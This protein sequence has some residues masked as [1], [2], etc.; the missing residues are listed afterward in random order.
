MK[1]LLISVIA[2]FLVF[3]FC[4]YAYFTPHLTLTKIQEAA[5]TG[6][7]RA[8]NEYVDLELVR[9]S[10]KQQIRMRL[11]G[12]AAHNSSPLAALGSAL[13]GALTEPAVD[14]LVTPEN[15]ARLLNGESFGASE[16]PRVHFEGK[17]VDM[18]YEGLDRFVVSTGSG[19]GF[20]FVLERQ[21]LLGWRLTDV[22]L[23]DAWNLA[24]SA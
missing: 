11:N 13:A 14:T 5:Q 4:A 22:I 15:I 9:T 7:T 18:R 3:A 21:G 20:R 23:P 1:K 19:A 24:G 17:S 16:G 12:T 8:L 6:N 10:L 2:L